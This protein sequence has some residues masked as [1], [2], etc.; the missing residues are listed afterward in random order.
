M[1]NSVQYQEC[2]PF[3]VEARLSF[4]RLETSRCQITR[5]PGQKTLLSNLQGEVGQAAAWPPC[6]AG[7][8]WA[9]RGHAFSQGSSRGA[10]ARVPCRSD[11]AAPPT[12]RL[13]LRGSPCR[14]LGAAAQAHPP[15]IAKSAKSSLKNFLP[16]PNLQGRSKPITHT[17][18]PHHH[19][20]GG[21]GRT[22]LKCMHRR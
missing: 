3:F 21:G 18:K 15:T 8:G 13:P 19:L 10:P 6:H 9:T 7:H 12:I 2:L 4:G 5:H 11:R 17:P 16:W 14:R 22:S 20:T 1:Q